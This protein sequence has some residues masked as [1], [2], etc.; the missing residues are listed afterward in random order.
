[1]SNPSDPE[2]S[3]TGDLIWS[4]WSQPYFSE[5]RIRSRPEGSAV[6]ASPLVKMGM[7]I[8]YNPACGTG[9]GREPLFVSQR[10]TS[11]HE[12]IDFSKKE[13][14]SAFSNLYSRPKP[15]PCRTCRMFC[16]IMWPTL[17]KKSP[18]YSYNTSKK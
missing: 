10:D 2:N 8:R 7:P 5:F 16:E 13:V 18:R 4:I 14:V 11:R 3:L 6:N 9:I 1:M 17:W 15:L 12:S